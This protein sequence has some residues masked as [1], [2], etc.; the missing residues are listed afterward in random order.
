MVIPDSH[1]ITFRVESI[2]FHFRIKINQSSQLG[3]KK[4]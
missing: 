2:N 1:K 4:Y 3:M